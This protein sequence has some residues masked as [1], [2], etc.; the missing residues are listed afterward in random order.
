MKCLLLKFPLLETKE[1]Q[2]QG[3]VCKVKLAFSLFLHTQA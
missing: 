2:M 3:N 1:E